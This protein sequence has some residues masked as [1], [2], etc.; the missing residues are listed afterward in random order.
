[1]SLHLKPGNNPI[2]QPTFKLSVSKKPTDFFR[3]FLQSTKCL[4]WMYTDFK[5]KLSQTL[6]SLLKHTNFIEKLI[7][8]L[9]SLCWSFHEKQCIF[10]CTW[11]FLMQTQSKY[12]RFTFGQQFSFAHDTLSW[13][14]S[15]V[16]SHRQIQCQHNS[17]TIVTKILCQWLNHKINLDYKVMNK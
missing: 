17:P 4:L 9:C 16:E 13:V 12:G 3:L 1:M 7:H 6:W 8:I 15:P 2:S 14:D 11:L 10:I 5:R